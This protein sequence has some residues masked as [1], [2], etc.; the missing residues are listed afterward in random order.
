MTHHNKKTIYLIDLAY[1]TAVGYSSDMMPL[2]LG[3][4]AAYCLKEHVADV[5]IQ[6][7][8]FVN[9]LI[10]A[11][12]KA[13]PYPYII[14]ASNYMWN[15]NLTHA[16]VSAIKEKHPGII[17]IFGGPNYPEVFEEQTEWLGKYPA[18][19]FYIYKDGEFAFSDLVGYLLK[20]PNIT[21]VKKAKL[22]CVH[23]L[24]NHH[25]YFGELKPRAIDLSV[26]PSPYLMGL[27]DKFFSQKLLPTIQTNRGCPF[28]C[29]YC[30]E[31]GLYYNRVAKR[32]FGHKKAEIDYIVAHVK[33]TKTLRITDSNF[34]MYEEDVEFCRYLSGIQEKY[35]YPEYVMCST[36]KNQ[37]DRVLTCNQLLHSAMRLTAS[38]QSL[39]AE[40]LKNVRRNNI[41]L[42]EILALSDKVS[43]TDTHSYSEIILGLPGDSL[44]AE[45]ESIEGLMKAGISNITQHQLSLIYGAEVATAESRKKYGIKS[46][47]RPQQRSLGV[48]EYQG[49]KIY[50]IE[51][52]EICTS[53]NTLSFADYL[54]ARRLYLTVGLFYNDRIFGEI[55]AL[56]RLL[57][58]STWAWLKRLHD[59]IQSGSGE[60]KALYQGFI[61]DTRAELWES[62]EKLTAEIKPKI[63]K[64][65]SGELGG[66]IIY[67]Y[68]SRGI[69][70]HFDKMHAWAFKNLRAY[71][72]DEGV[73]ADELVADV[74]KYSLYQK[75]D[76]FNLAYSL[77]ETFHYDIL[78]MIKEPA[79]MRQATAKDIHYPIKVKISHSDSQKEMINRQ[80]KFYGQSLDQLTMLISR[81]P[82]KRFYR[83]VEK[84]S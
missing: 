67:K 72:H 57:K 33:H 32:N 52:E 41:S 77:E 40:V 50:G 64:Y 46:M 37:K 20:N 35:G 31:G 24:I 23:S 74:E 1:D 44:A 58:L 12:E 51:I 26:I 15:I 5:D 48:Y 14:G 66:N 61:A 30:T 59:D 28:T 13:P 39:N 25:P 3:L 68:R 69:V 71:L 42:D 6:I 63:E 10:E 29:T 2:Q 60:I 19:D 18:I 4:I 83:Q 17:S 65:M 84:I 73:K 11:V 22:P 7:F 47:F 36:G 8:K 54:A 76:I 81:F 56:L 75:N 79:L 38:V 70:S 9:E 53:T 82:L 80:R 62:P 27:M 55:H 45:M 21:E 16:L 34:G 78:K 49:E 43:D